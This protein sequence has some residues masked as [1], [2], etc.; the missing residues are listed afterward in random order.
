MN[1]VVLSETSFL[2]WKRD[3]KEKEKQY[4]SKHENQDFYLC[5]KTKN[6]S[7]SVNF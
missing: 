3:V 6:K 5:D 4:R 1:L 2:L 7:K